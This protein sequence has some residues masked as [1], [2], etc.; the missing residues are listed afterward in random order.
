MTIPEGAL[1]L[2]SG[3][4]IQMCATTRGYRGAMEQDG[5]GTDPGG[6]SGVMDLGHAPRS[7]DVSTG[8]DGPKGCHGGAYGE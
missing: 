1:M 2:P 5:A 6:V 3:G 8:L 7:N 4:S